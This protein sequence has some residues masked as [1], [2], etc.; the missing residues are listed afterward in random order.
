MYL[1]P[2]VYKARHLRKILNNN[3]NNNNN[4]KKKKKKKEEAWLGGKGDPLKIMQEIK[5]LPY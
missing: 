2:W 5:I 4:K 1:T 3:K